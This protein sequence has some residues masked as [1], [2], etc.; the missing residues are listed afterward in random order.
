MRGKAPVVV[1][2]EGGA[3]VEIA[4]A[5]GVGIAKQIGRGQRILRAQADTLAGGKR[6]A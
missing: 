6:H 4:A 1:N 5:I 2:G 3:E